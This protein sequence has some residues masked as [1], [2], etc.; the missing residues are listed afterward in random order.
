MANLIIPDKNKHQY[1]VGIDYGH[2]ETSAAICPIEWGKEAG[3][4]ETNVL[5]IDLDIAARKKVITSAICHLEKGIL[6]GDEAFEHMTDN[7]GIRVCF[8]K[9]P[10]SITGKDEKLMIDYMKAVYSRIRE[11][12]DELTDTNHIVYI[13]RPSGWTDEDSKELYR[14]MAIQAGIPLGG[15]TS[16]SRAAIF[17]AKSPSVNF[18]KEISQGAIVFDL[19]SS[20][21]DFTYLS[22]KEKPIDFGYNLGASIIDNAILDELILKNDGV[23]DFVTKFPE[24]RDALKFKARKFKED[25]YSRNEDSKTI[26][27]FP[28]GNI[29]SETEDSYDDFADTYVK[30]RVNNLAELNS[31]IEEKAH[32]MQELEKAMNDFKQTKIDGKP[33]FGVFLTGGASRMNFI[34]PLI[35]KVFDLPIDKVKIDNDNPSL[36]ISRGIALLGSTDVI[37]SVLVKSLKKELPS[38]INNE[39]MIV[40]LS[41]KLSENITSKAWKVVEDSC[42]YWVKKGKTTDEEELKKIV[43]DRL[44]HFKNYTVPTIVNDTVQQFIKTSTEDIRKKVNEIVSLY[45][46]GREISSSGNVKIENLQAIN[47]SLSSMSSSISQICDSISN[48]IADILWAVLGGLLWGVFCLPYYAWKI[49]RSDESKR[50]DKADKILEKQGQITANIEFDLLKKIRWNSAFKDSVTKS[51]NSYFT[52]IMETNLQQ[53]IIPIE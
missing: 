6:I 13:A 1:V 40:D 25:A 29:I 18:S 11:G 17:Y 44:G 20:T 39:K 22:D 21:L 34:R 23:K 48:V 33:V 49:F 32:Y 27:G 30:L 5:D 42:S 46:P 41:G 50:Q 3:K 52:K 37:T 4:R 26:G 43:Q 24:Y 36:T 7:N 12:H 31:M 8:K 47:E 19:G 35:A 45:A 2:G 28:L 9:K 51:L 16:E 10:Q 53:V 38:M 14:Q 15:L